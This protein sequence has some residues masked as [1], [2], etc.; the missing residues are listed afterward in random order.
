M[1]E[2]IGKIEK[3]GFSLERLVDY[4][5]TEKKADSQARRRVLMNL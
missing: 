5:T 4:K 3:L 1:F 2:M